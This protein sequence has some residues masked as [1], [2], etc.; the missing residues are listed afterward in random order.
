[1]EKV[2]NWFKLWKFY[3]E[4]WN[5]TLVTYFFLIKSYLFCLRKVTIGNHLTRSTGLLKYNIFD[6]YFKYMNPGSIHL[7]GDRIMTEELFG[8]QKKV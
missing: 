4:A 2:R 5:I 6:P 1:M 3:I 7:I 8:Y